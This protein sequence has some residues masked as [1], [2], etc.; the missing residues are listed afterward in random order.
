MKY[1]SCKELNAL[2]RQLVREGWCYSRGRK[3]GKLFPPAGGDRITVTSSPSDWRAVMNFRRDVRE[4]SRLAVARNYGRGAH[5][6][7]AG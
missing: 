1:S 7:S 5:D 4:Y 3:H 6:H 2:I